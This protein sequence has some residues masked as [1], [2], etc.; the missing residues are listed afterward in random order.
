MAPC[1]IEGFC[2]AKKNCNCVTVFGKAVLYVLLLEGFGVY[3][4]AAASRYVEKLCT[5]VSE[6]SFL[7]LMYMGFS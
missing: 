5:I 7:V 1:G 4:C 2:Y 6:E 3:I